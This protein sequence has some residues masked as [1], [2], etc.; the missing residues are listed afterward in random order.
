MSLE[1]LWSYMVNRGYSKLMLIQAIRG[2]PS[3]ILLYTPGFKK[4][5][6]KGVI[7]LSGVSL[8]VDKKIGKT[9]V[10]ELHVSQKQHPLEKLLIDFLNPPLYDPERTGVTA[11]L[12]VEHLDNEARLIFRDKEGRELYPVLKVRRWEAADT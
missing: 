8:T 1:D 2:N 12:S 11:F 3:R 10:K 7:Y 4:L 9:L 5:D 6:L